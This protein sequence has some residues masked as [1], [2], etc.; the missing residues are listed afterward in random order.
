MPRGLL[1][2]TGRE[3]YELCGEAL[4]LD[5]IG[6]PNLLEEH[7]HSSRSAAWYWAEFKNLNLLADK[8]GIGRIAERL[9]VSLT[10][11]AELIHHYERAKRVLGVEP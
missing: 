1:K 3:N 2:I 11:L 6:N 9:C 4:G 10:G 5:L 7:P 8:G